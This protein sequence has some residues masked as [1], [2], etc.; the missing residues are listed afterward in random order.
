MGPKQDFTTPL[1]RGKYQCISQTE[2][3]KC[4]KDEVTAGVNKPKATSVGG[5]KIKG[6]GGVAESEKAKTFRIARFIPQKL[7][8]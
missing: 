2:R 6:L 3:T 4:E 5:E 1:E 8:G 7:S